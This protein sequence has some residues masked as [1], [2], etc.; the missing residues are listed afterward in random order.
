VVQGSKTDTSPAERALQ[1]PFSN[2]DFDFFYE[3][4]A[5]GHLLV[6]R[7]N[8]CGS[9]RNPPCPMCPHCRSLRWVGVKCVGGGTLYSY[10]VHY[11]PPLPSFDTPHPIALAEM[12]EGFRLVGS[13]R[14]PNIKD[15]YIGMPL[16]VEVIRRG[17]VATFHF[18]P[19][20]ASPSTLE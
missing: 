15:I 2:R 20:L 9:F 5:A 11:H 18:V 14:V 10:T 7:C 19:A 4:L 1:A 17:Q 13:L 12:S 8:G 16:N 3:G 6:Q